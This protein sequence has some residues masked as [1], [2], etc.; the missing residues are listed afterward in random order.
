MVL[1]TANGLICAS[2]ISPLRYFANSH[3]VL[4]NLRRIRIAAARIR[5]AV[6]AFNAQFCCVPDCVLRTNG[7]N[8]N[9]FDNLN[10]VLASSP[11]LAQV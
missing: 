1:P 9:I 11:R 3:F 10:H 8:Q 6:R 4:R 2:N 5:Q 7:A